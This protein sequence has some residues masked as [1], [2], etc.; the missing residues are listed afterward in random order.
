MKNSRVAAA[1]ILASLIMQRGSL[2]SLL[3]NY[4]DQPDFQLLQ[5]MVY[6]SCRWF[7]QLEY[8]LS[9]LLSKPIKQK[10]SDIKALLIVGLYQ[11]REMRV[12]DH[13]AI[14][15]TVAATSLL[16][17]SWAKGLVNAVLRNYLRQ[18][19]SLKDSLQEQAEAIQ[20]SHPSWLSDALRL[21]W[22]QHYPALLAA[23]NLRPPMTLRVN[24]GR[25]NRQD[26]LALL[27]QNGFAASA[28]IL[29][30]SSVYLEQPASVVLLPGFA[31]GMVSVQDE[32]SQLVPQLLELAPGQRVL[33]AC[34]APGG[35]TCHMLE[36]EHS[37][38][39]LTA[40]ERES[41]R[42]TRIRE[43]LDRLHLQARVVRA[44]ANQVSSWWDGK[45]FDRILLDAPCSASGVIR[46]HPDIKLLR[47]PDAINDL[48]QQQEQLL[49]SLW[50]CLQTGGLLLYTTCSVLKQENDDLV[51]RFLNTTNDA[52]Y[53]GVAA[54]WGV[55]CDY[56]RQLLPLEQNGPDGFFYSLL[57]RA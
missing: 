48:V 6:G 45:P 3:D 13:A 14:N 36:S 26:Y 7:Q 15:E 47:Q 29:C 1:R 16:D 4:K 2:F 39:E 11:L 22:P 31:D 17:K 5:E 21:S 44:D 42:V 55:E 37:L 10:D 33:D 27:E 54:D 28:G 38:T 24:Q 49:R 35:K 52:K 19:Q 12:P 50:P 57:R 51:A 40:L 43:N 8:L 18:E 23:N 9:R 56:G 32:A 25:I 30:D 41:T 53:E 46:R 34:A 20:Y